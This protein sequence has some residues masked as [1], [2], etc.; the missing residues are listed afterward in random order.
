MLGRSSN[1]K[2]GEGLVS[3]GRSAMCIYNCSMESPR[4]R[5]RLDRERR[6]S[7]HENVDLR[8]SER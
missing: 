5:R 7:H 6:R 1:C 8:C 3:I 2:R 4:E